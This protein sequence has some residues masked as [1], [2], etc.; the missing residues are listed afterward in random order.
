MNC[1]VLELIKE[2]QYDDSK[3]EAAIKQLITIFEPKI[4]KSLNNTS[5]QNKSD[6]EQELVLKM[7]EI[8][9]KYEVDNTINIFDYICIDN[10]QNN[11]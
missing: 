5:F 10:S 3:R 1:C 7:I 4:K 8:V 6:L 9:D 11:V 2:V